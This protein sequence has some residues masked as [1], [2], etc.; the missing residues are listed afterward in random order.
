MY[1]TRWN[2]ILLIT[3]IGLVSLTRAGRPF[4]L[5]YQQD[6]S[7]LVK[8]YIDSESHLVNWVRNDLAIPENHLSPLTGSFKYTMGQPIEFI[9]DGD[10]SYLEPVFT[11]L[12]MLKVASIKPGN[13]ES[14]SGLVYYLN[15]ELHPLG[16]LVPHN[17]FGHARFDNQWI[18]CYV[19]P[20]DFNIRW[21]FQAK[22]PRAILSPYNTYLQDDYFA[23]E[24][25]HS[26][27]FLET[28]EALAPNDGITVIRPFDFSEILKNAY[29]ELSDTDRGNGL[30]YIF[31]DGVH[32]DKETYK[33]IEYGSYST[34][35]DLDVSYNLS[36]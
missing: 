1:L 20:K 32:V 2:H 19:D 27:R 18:V 3:Y 17:D 13:I 21:E 31:P 9:P 22:G 5:A 7:I 34:T 35:S 36:V 10:Q 8:C 24:L 15:K 26:V 6:H 4:G 33:S 14:G 25:N 29:I 23:V 28:T 30:V 11:F 12:P 16:M